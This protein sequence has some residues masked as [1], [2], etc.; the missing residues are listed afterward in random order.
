[1]MGGE[2]ATARRGIDSADRAFIEEKRGLGIGV[3][4]IA[5][6]V[7]CSQADVRAVPTLRV[8]HSSVAA[9]TPEVSA[10]PI[11]RIARI[12][13]GLDDMALRRALALIAGLIEAQQGLKVAETVISN[14]IGA[15]RRSA[16]PSVQEI[17][18][19]V[20]T[21]YGVTPGELTGRE[22]RRAVSNARHAAYF[23]VKRLRPWLSLPALGRIFGRDHTT[24][25]HGIR[26]HKARLLKEP[27]T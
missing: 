5:R 15:A 20:A 11:D 23:E 19:Q 6:M 7:G 12:A 27:I 16:A 1:M 10:D 4:N 14:V 24:I 2:F 3:D 18:R 8:V 9:P 17:L 26:A 21:N 22:T 13:V 25:L